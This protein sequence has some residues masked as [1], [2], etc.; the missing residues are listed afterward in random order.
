MIA[1]LPIFKKSRTSS[2]Q[3]KRRK[4]KKRTSAFRKR[5]LPLRVSF[6]RKQKNKSHVKTAVRFSKTKVQVTAAIQVSIPTLVAPKNDW[7]RL[8]SS[9]STRS[10]Q[11]HILQLR[12]FWRPKLKIMT[13][14][15]RCWASSSNRLGSLRRQR[16]TLK[17]QI[18]NLLSLI[19]WPTL[20]SWKH[21]LALLST[22]SSTSHSSTR[23]LSLTSNVQTRYPTETQSQFKHCS[24]C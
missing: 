19:C 22:P 2:E 8:S 14:S 10:L 12:W 4:Q 17:T 11:K 6:V 7:L 24:R 20:L 23:S 3:S 16:S 9:S 13:S 21:C 18:S 5:G 1:T 15:D